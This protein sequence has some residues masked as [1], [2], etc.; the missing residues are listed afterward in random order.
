[1]GIKA[2]TMI[3]RSAREQ[4]QWP[5]QEARVQ[6]R[7]AVLSILL[8]SMSAHGCPVLTH[9]SG[10]SQQAASWRRQ[11]KVCFL[12]FGPAAFDPAFSDNEDDVR[13]MPKDDLYRH[14]TLQRSKT[15][16]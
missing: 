12:F 8:F 6:V 10:Q 9:Q 2:P 16:V 3:P 15:N 11:W 13:R 14:Q 1:M 7:C 5:V 4:L